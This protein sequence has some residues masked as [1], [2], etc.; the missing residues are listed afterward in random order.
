MGGYLKA[1]F[2]DANLEQISTHVQAGRSV[3]HPDG[4]Y[5]WI[6]FQLI[7]ILARPCGHRGR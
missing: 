3:F 7:N 2:I 4:L 6:F 5:L 1:F